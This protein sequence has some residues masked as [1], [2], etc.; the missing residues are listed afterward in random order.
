MVFCASPILEKT[1]YLVIQWMDALTD[2]EKIAPGLVISSF[3]F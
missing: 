2:R 1:P 3:L